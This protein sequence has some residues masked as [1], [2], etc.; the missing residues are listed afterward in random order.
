[1]I[2]IAR[3][4]GAPESVPAG[5]P[6]IS[7]STGSCRASI[8]LDVGDDVH[9]VAVA[10]DEEAARSRATEP[11]FGDTR[12]TSLRP[13]SSSIRCSARSLGSASSSSAERLVLLGVVAAR[14]G[15]RRAGGWSSCRRAGAPGSPALE[16][17]SWK[18]PKSRKN[19]NGEGLVAAASGRARTASAGTAPRSR[20]RHHLEDVAGADVF[21][22][23]LDHRQVVL[24]ASCWRA[25]AAARAPM[26][27][28]RRRL[29]S[30]ALE[31]A[32]DVGEPRA[33]AGHRPPRPVRRRLADGRHH[34]DLVGDDV[35]DGDDRRP[36]Q[37]PVG[38]AER[39]SGICGS[40]STSR[41]MS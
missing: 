15:C 27:A 38:N 23:P 9:D 10:L 3:T 40:R 7:T 35:E 12:P 18:P 37:E 25:A 2:S 32:S 19:R 5:K 29:G 31:S 33:G 4:L 1:M 8:A 11:D 26:P 21:L 28:A 6:A 24:A 22:G 14:G 13:R 20:S 39:S 36:H 17:T 16:P 34:G 30:G 41:T